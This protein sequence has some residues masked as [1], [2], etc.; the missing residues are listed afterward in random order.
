M[1]KQDLIYLTGELVAGSGKSVKVD[2]P[3]DGKG[4]ATVVQEP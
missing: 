1:S 4:R 3:C 2:V